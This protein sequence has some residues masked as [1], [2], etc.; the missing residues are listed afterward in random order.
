MTS[1]LDTDIIIDW[2]FNLPLAVRTLHELEPAGLAIS[3]ATYGELLA[4]VP[5]SRDPEASEQAI[6]AFLRR[7][8]ILPLSRPVIA[9]FARLKAESEG[10]APPSGPAHR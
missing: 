1:L 9:R 2:L 8:R 7:V 4:G 3:L 6:R 5:Y 10:R